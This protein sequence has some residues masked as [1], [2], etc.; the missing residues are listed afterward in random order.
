ME[1]MRHAEREVVLRATEHVKQVTH[2]GTTRQVLLNVHFSQT[3]LTNSISNF[4]S[5]CNQISAPFLHFIHIQ[6]A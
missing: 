3:Y 1:Q 4:H 5:K 6:N 2:V